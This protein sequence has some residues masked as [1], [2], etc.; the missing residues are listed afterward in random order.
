MNFK[1]IAL[2]TTTVSALATIAHANSDDHRYNQVRFTTEVSQEVAND[3]LKVVL[4]KSTQSTD[5]QT[6][7]KTLT[8]TLN[9]AQDIAKKYPDVKVKT[10]NQRTYP[11]YNNNGKIIGYTG[12][13]SIE[14][15]ST[16]F[17]QASELIAKLQNIMA[18]ERLSFNVSEKSEEVAKKALM[19]RAIKTFQSDA[20]NI[21][22]SFGARGYKIVSVQLDTPNIH[23]GYG[24]PVMMMAKDASAEMAAPPSYEAGDSR[25]SY[26]ATGTI[27]LIK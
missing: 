17:T 8:T 2:L 7:A 6:I 26:T 15:T 14:L 1:K 20:T 3:E 10:N 19:E 27:E 18:I 12:S 13:V 9:Q 24:V 4:E 23:G 16:N 21:S 5:I 11:R 22:N 25:I